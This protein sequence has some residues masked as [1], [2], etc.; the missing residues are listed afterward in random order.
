MTFATSQAGGVSGEARAIPLEGLG[1]SAGGLF[2]FF[3]Q[4]N[5]EMLV[6][7]LDGCGV[8]GNYWVFYSAGTNVGFTVTVDDTATGRRRTY[9]NEDRTAAPPVQDTA[10]F[11]CN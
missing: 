1:V 5:P 3:G 7:V 9:D 2:W 8:N 6:K 4:E 10:A 11:S